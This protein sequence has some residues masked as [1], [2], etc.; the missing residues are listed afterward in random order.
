MKIRELT[1]EEFA[2][3]EFSKNNQELVAEYLEYVEETE[4][5]FG[6]PLEWKEWLLSKN[7]KVNW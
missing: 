2:E 7:I 1:A 6:E 5:Y 4:D 3:I